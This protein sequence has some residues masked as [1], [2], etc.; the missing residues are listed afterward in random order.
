MA[1]Q[2]AEWEEEGRGV[3]ALGWIEGRLQPGA[4]HG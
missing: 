3:P 2:E 4:R 1:P